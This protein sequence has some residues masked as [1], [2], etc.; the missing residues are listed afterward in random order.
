MFVFFA[1]TAAY[2]RERFFGRPSPPKIQECQTADS[3]EK[4]FSG[5]LQNGLNDSQMHLVGRVSMASFSGKMKPEP[6][7]DWSPLGA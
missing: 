5:V 2:I 7:P 4:W 3:K 6:R 1:L